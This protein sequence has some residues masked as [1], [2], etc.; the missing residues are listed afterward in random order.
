MWERDPTAQPVSWKL[1]W[2]L[3]EVDADQWILNAHEVLSLVTGSTPP[4][5]V[6]VAKLARIQVNANG[7]AEFTV[8]GGS[9][10]RTELISRKEVR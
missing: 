9:A 4:T 8:V 5:S 10:P 7:Q 3:S 6:D 2:T 1:H